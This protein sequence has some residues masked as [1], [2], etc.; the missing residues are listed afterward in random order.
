VLAERFGLPTRVLDGAGHFV[1]H[2]APQALADVV[3]DVVRQ[4]RARR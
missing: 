4:V 2:D 3:L 1:Q